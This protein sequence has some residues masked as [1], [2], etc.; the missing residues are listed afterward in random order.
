MEHEL[1]DTIP[2]GT[3]CG[4]YQ[5]A[6]PGSFAIIDEKDFGVGTSGL[7][8][9]LFFKPYLSKADHAQAVI[10]TLDVSKKTG[11][12][13]VLTENGTVDFWI[14][15]GMTVDGIA[16]GF[17]PRGWTELQL[18][19]QNEA[20]EYEMKPIASFTEV[21]E[22]ALREKRQLSREA[23][24]G[25]PCTMLFAASFAVNPAERSVFPTNFF[26]GRIDSPTLRAASSPSSILAKWDFSRCISSDKICDIS[27]ACA[28]GRLVNAPTRAVTGRDWDA[29]ESD[30]TKAKYGYGAIHFHEDDLDDAGW[31]T[32]LSINLPRTLRSGV[33]GVVVQSADGM[34]GD[35]VPFYVRPT[36][37]TNAALGA[38]VAYIISTF[39]VR[40]FR[41][42]P[43]SDGA[44]VVPSISPTQM[45]MCTTGCI[46]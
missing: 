17:E 37:T 1:V 7:N 33:Y 30:W 36:E 10:S 23:K 11:F 6:H 20:I 5:V 34:V 25:G 41:L 38:R 15:N 13:V 22:P 14:G 32:D 9:S 26:N 44:D 42:E 28:H 21:T 39:T 43:V 19:I 16:S 12:A 31:E 35:T 45:N 27:G 4:R 3:F 18:T 2:H 29:T 40:I 8:M 24:V 46:S